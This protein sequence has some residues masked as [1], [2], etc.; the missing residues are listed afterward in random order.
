MPPKKI[1]E[2]AVRKLHEMAKGES[3]EGIYLGSEQASKEGTDNKWLVFKLFTADEGELKI[4][5]SDLTK[6]FDRITARK[7]ADLDGLPYIRISCSAISKFVSQQDGSDIEY[8]IACV[9][10][11]DE[12]DLTAGLR[13]RAKQFLLGGGNLATRQPVAAG[14]RSR[15]DEGLDAIFAS[16]DEIPF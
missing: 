8:H 14:S 2:D 15:N 10:L 3:Y 4:T 5:G 6:K 7:E 11:F 1:G 16:E 9:E 13:A 12:D